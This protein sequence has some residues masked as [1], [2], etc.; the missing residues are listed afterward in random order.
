MDSLDDSYSLTGY[1]PNAYDLKETYVE[2][3][4][5]LP[6]RPTVLEDVEYDDTA[7]EDML[8]EAH[9]VRG[10]CSPWAEGGLVQRERKRD[11]TRS[12]LGS[13]VFSL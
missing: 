11:W 5:E 10:A 12:Y 8:R 7:L 4:T 13:S 3:Y 1:E 6:D 2:S 9:R